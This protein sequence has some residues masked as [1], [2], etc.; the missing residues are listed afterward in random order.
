MVQIGIGYICIMHGIYNP[1]VDGFLNS[2]GNAM[3]LPPHYLEVVLSGSW[4][5]DL[6][7]VMYRGGLL[8]VLLESFWKGPRGLSYIFLI[9]W[10][11]STLEPVDGSIFV[12]YRVLILR[13]NQD[14]FN[15]FIALEVGLYAILA[16]DLLDA[17]A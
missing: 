16:A 8:Q 4:T 10:K 15:G 9:T 1:Y 3:V 12:F 11:F 14:V 2:S 17:F 13:G 7:V 5:S 6:T